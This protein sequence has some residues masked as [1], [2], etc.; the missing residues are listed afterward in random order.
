MMEG[1]REELR[2]GWTWIWFDM[3]NF[4]HQSYSSFHLPLLRLFLFIDPFGLAVLYI[5]EY[6]IIAYN[7]CTRLYDLR[8]G[9][10]EFTLESLLLNPHLLLYL[11]SN[12]SISC[13]QST[14]LL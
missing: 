10:F 5:S 12:L 14:T 13:E 2:R 3:R 6:L 11:L 9:V 8:N 4:F 1:I 7:L